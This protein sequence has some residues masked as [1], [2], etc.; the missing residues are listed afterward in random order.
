MIVSATSTRTSSAFAQDAAQTATDPAI[1]VLETDVITVLEVTEP[2]PQC[3]VDAGDDGR[4]IMAVVASCLGPEI[5]FELGQAALPRP[6]RQA[7]LARPL[8]V[9]AQEV[10]TF[11]PNVHDSGLRRMH[12][13]TSRLAPLTYHR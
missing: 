8:E 7:S 12:H 5:G 11:R 13:Q 3:R 6:T 4:Q 9:V 10:K 1:Q 2:T